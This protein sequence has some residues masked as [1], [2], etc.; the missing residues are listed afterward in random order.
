MIYQLFS[1][2]TTQVQIRCVLLGMDG[3]N[4]KLFL[5]TKKNFMTT[6]HHFIGASDGISDLILLLWVIVNFS[7]EEISPSNLS[8]LLGHF[9]IFSPP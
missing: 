3:K 1:T 4:L 6:L 9:A 2:L 7:F 8:S 5:R